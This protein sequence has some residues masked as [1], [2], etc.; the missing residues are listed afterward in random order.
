MR[1]DKE[2]T[3]HWLFI[4]PEISVNR[5]LLDRHTLR[6]ITRLVHIGAA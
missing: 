5:V 2:S 4:P 3:R 6:Q 1:V